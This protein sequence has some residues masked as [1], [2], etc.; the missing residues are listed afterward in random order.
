ML[1]HV[2]AWDALASLLPA[3]AS[4]PRGCLT[5]HRERNGWCMTSAQIWLA[6]EAKGVRYATVREMASSA[7]EVRWPDGRVQ[8]DSLAV[9]RELDAAFPDTPPLWPP[10]GVAAADVDAMV[11]AFA[12]TMPAN[13][14]ESSRVAHLFCSDEGFVYDPLPR[15]AFIDTL[16]GTEALLGQ[17]EV[18]VCH[19]S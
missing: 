12:A 5:L 9:L 16:D 6:L 13:A 11:A 19:E 1:L 3:A 15:A 4:P 10:P 7:P 17:H 8:R 14:R 2:P 18:R